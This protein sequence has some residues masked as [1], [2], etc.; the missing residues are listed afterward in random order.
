MPV[1][2]LPVQAERGV[3]RYAV[4]EGGARVGAAY[5]PPHT[6][7]V[8]PPG[9]SAWQVPAPPPQGAP[10]TAQGWNATG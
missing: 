9:V 3:S 2:P 8:A 6:Q 10:P 1:P 7:T 5:S 4:C